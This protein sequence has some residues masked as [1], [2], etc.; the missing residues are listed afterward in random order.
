VIA[1]DTSSLRRYLAGEKGRDVDAVEAA[2][3]HRSAA[4]PPVVLTEMLSHPELHVATR[5]AISALPLFDLL[6][7]YWERA[8]ALRAGVLRSGFKARIADTLV[9]QTCIDHDALLVT[10][11]RGFRHFVSFGLRLL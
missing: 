9:A 2:M 1:L 10:D 3:S 11:D 8:G 4:L 5:R 6:D 7:G